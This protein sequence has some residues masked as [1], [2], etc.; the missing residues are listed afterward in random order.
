MSSRKRG[1]ER[2]RDSCALARFG[3]IAASGMVDM[4]VAKG[5]CGDVERAGGLEQDGEREAGRSGRLRQEREGQ[6]RGEPGGSK[7]NERV[8]WGWEWRGGGMKRRGGG[9]REKGRRRREQLVDQYTHP[10]AGAR[11]LSLRV[12]SAAPLCSARLGTARS[13]CRPSLFAISLLSSLSPSPPPY[14]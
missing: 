13:C 11:I 12:C 9:G 7:R 6:R 2:K 5:C 3:Y 14:S 10:S 1:K 4:R 8:V